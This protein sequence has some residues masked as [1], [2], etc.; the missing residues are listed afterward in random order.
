MK[1]AALD[2]AHYRIPLATPLSDSTHGE[3]TS[4]ELITA[5]LRDDE[6][7]EGRA[8]PTPWAGGRRR[9]WRCWSTIWLP[10]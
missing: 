10:W 9:S 1:I 5:R 4:F 7:A 2:A 6:G 3:M 8:T